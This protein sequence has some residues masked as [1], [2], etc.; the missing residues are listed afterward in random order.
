M[1]MRRVEDRPKVSIVVPIYRVERY[2]RQCIDS[3]LSQT[4]RDIEIILID[5]G[6]PDSCGKIIDEYASED[7]RIITIH[8]SNSGYS[9]AVNRGIA[10]A[11]GEYIGIIESDD[12]VESN[13]FEVLYK[14]ATKNN[15]DIAKCLFCNYDSTRPEGKENYPFIF[16]G[17]DIAKAPNHVFSAEEWPEIIMFHS[18]I[19]S[20][21]YK[22]DYVKHFKLLES[23]GAS[24]QDLP[25][26]IETMSNAKR[27]TLVKKVLIHWRNE[28]MQG[29]STSAR[30]E[31]LLLMVKNTKRSLDILRENRNYHKLSSAFLAQAFL[32]NVGFFLRINS[33]LKPT[34][35]AEMRGIIIELLNDGADFYFI[36]KEDISSVK[37]LVKSTNWR[38]FYLS[39]A[40]SS[41][42]RKFFHLRTKK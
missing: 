4:L 20:C 1:S 7:S 13:M 24:Y 31:K 12:W 38:I 36:R 19:W 26:M 15:S 40:W 37:T 16:P 3:L 9:K 28:P 17:I 6:S 41:L 25:F 11:H 21:I 8:Q 10:E 14:N 23:A 5:D 22:A 42:K 32:T 18:S 2:L 35:Y 29:N 33:K 30:S 39:F 34:Y 27:I